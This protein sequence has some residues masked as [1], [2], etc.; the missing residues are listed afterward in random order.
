MEF[1][2]TLNDYELLSLLGR[3]SQGSVYKAQIK[4][5]RQIIALKVI[6]MNKQNLKLAHEE[7]LGLEKLSIPTC[8]PFVVCYYGHHYDY[9]ENKLLIEMEY[10]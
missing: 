5:T 6:T 1:D 4:L 9:L 3:G 10:I 7:L 2:R 8:H